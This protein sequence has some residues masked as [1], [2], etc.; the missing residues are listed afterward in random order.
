MVKARLEMLTT[1]FA[2]SSAGIWERREGL[3]G[4]WGPL[5]HQWLREVLPENVAE[6]CSGRVSIMITEV[7]PWFMPFERRQVCRT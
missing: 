7:R 4:I 1:Y 3:A 5:I 6:L 2:T